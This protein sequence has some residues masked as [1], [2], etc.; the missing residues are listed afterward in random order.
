MLWCQTN[1][2]GR[3]GSLE[4]EEARKMEHK[5]YKHSLEHAIANDEVALYR[6]SDKRNETCARGIEKAIQESNHP[7]RQYNYDLPY[8]QP[9]G[10]CGVWDGARGLG[11]VGH[12]AESVARWPFFR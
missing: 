9:Q 7:L 12:S 1:E 11:V 8:C 3:A 4:E 5:V 2:K 10:S 6:D